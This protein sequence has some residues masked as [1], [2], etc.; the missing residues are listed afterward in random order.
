MSNYKAT[1]PGRLSSETT[2]L[3]EYLY[4]ADFLTVQEKTG[5]GEVVLAVNLKFL[6]LLEGREEFRLKHTPGGDL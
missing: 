6:E 4:F 1:S 2:T 3:Y 5:P